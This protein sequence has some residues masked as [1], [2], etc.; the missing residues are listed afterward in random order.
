[1]ACRGQVVGLG[2]TVLYTQPGGFGDAGLTV[3][4]WEPD[5][6]VPLSF[7]TVRVTR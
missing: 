3:I 5:A 2:L 1:M 6:V 7:T 4:D